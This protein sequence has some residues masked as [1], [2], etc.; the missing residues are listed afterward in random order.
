MTNTT[1]PRLALQGITKSY[2]GVAALADVSFS[3]RPG[4]VH[5]IVGENGAGKSTLLRILA[6]AIRADAGEI[7]IDG[8]SV[9]PRDA[10]HA[11]SLGISL[12]HQEL[13]LAPDL[14]VRDNVY[15][16]CWPRRLGLFVDRNE[17]TRKTENLFRSL[18]MNLPA[19]ATVGSLSVAQRQMVEIAKALAFDSRLLMLDEPSAVLTPGELATL[20]AVIRDLTARGASVIYVSHRIDEVFALAQEITVLRDGRHISTRPI[21]AVSRESLIADVVE[22]ALSEEFPRRNVTIG[23]VAIA[24]KKLSA[25]KRFCGVSFDIRSGEV[26]GLCGM[27]GSGRSS[28]GKALFGAIPEIRGDVRIDNKSGPFRS[29]REAIRAGV[30]LV[31]EDRRHEGLLMQR[32]VRNNIALADLRSVSRVGFVSNRNERGRVASLVSQ[33]RIKASGLDARV[34]SLSGGNQQKSLLAR[35]MTRRH[36]VMILDEPTRGIDVGAKAEVYELIN[37]LAADGMA[38]LLISSELPEVV[39]MADRIGV[40][41]RGRL[42]GVFDNRNRHV[43]QEQLL[44]C[45]VSDIA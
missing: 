25:G 28:V 18:G 15:L 7:R 1:T 21:S 35:W 9:S 8:E 38:I 16:G 34:S 4:C 30:V 23:E 44:A 10:R 13:N 6:G 29:P 12:V 3:I 26:F 27:V 31:P 37:R 32:S 41:R 11:K 14:S 20:F 24:V 22:R 19:T 36:R 42:A 43:T 5:A 40:M 45:A 2:G 39:G 17:L 33:L